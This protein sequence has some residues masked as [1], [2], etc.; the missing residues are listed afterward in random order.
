MT[1]FVFERS[2]RSRTAML[3]LIA[4]WGA[5]LSLWIL[6]DAAPFVVALLL[7]FTLPAALDF[8][9]GR[10][11]GLRLDDARLSWH[12]GRQEAEIALARLT[13]V[14]FERR[15]DLTM[16]VRVVTDE[17][18]RIKIPQDALPPP[19]ELENALHA[20]EVRVEKHPFSL[21]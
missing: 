9:L 2:P 11:A 6:V 12:S 16:R 4:V 14:R 19:A 3:V 5:V 15:L 18:K 17:G 13:A 1:P 10:R 21:L 7:A 8:A 20:R